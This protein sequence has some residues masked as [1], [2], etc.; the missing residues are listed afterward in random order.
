MPPGQCPVS[1]HLFLIL[2]TNSVIFWSSAANVVE[3]TPARRRALQT[4]MA[5]TT[6]AAELSNRLSSVA[7]SAGMALIMTR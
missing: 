5:K 7:A 4:T 1:A 6:A 2:S 3:A